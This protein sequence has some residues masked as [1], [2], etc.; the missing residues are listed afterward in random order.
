MSDCCVAIN[1]PSNAV[2]VPVQAMTRSAV[3]DA[4]MR[5]A[6]RTIR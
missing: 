4:W 3:C 2:T 6:T 1:A 5:K